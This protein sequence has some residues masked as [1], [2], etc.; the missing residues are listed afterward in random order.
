M[1]AWTKQLDRRFAG[2]V[3]RCVS[4]LI[5]AGGDVK[6]ITYFFDATLRFRVTARKFKC[7]RKPSIGELVF[8]MGKPN[9]K[10]RKML[11]R[12]HPKFPFV[13]VKEFT[14]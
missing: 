2:V 9:Y 13:H 11:K 7:Y 10:E 5:Q 12:D 6:E 8:V 4:Q 1:N 14:A 3:G